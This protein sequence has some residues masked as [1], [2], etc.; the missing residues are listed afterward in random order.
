MMFSETDFQK[1]YRQP[2]QLSHVR[3]NNDDEGFNN[4]LRICRYTLDKFTPCKK[5]DIRDN[6]APFINKT[7]SKGIMKRSNL[8]NNYLKCRSEEDLENK[9]FMCISIKK[10]N[11]KLLFELKQKKCYR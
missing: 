7:L 10:D 5:K 9:K 4:F 2:Q 6:N 8:K 11:K 3:I 1:N